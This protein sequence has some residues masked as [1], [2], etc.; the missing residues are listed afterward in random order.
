MASSA[1][2]A[3]GKR[4]QTLRL[5]K[6]WAQAQLAEA[7]GVEAMTISRYERGSYAPSIEVLEQMAQ[8]LG[9]SMESFFAESSPATI[10]Q[11]KSDDLRH[12]LC[13]IAYQTKDI[14]VLEAIVSSAAKILSKQ[15]KD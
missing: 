10:E 4:L 12:S 1:K 11:P 7:M 8:V 9:C 14:K 3:L 15:R 2:K 5:A 13:D 6:N